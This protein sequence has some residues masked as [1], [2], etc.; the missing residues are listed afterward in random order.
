MK[1]L[2]EG[3][4]RTSFFTVSKKLL[5]EKMLFYDSEPFEVSNCKP[6]QFVRGEDAQKQPRGRIGCW[7]AARAEPDFYLRVTSPQRQKNRPCKRCGLTM[8][9]FHAL[10]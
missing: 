6:A 3:S 2:F 1:E 7:G 5:N 8:P 4:K 9:F 10:R